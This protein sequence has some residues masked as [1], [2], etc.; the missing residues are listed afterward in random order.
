MR[1]DEAL[2]VAA[3]ASE[4]ADADRLAEAE[5]RYRE[6]IARA[7]PRHY[8]TPDI[9]LEYAA[10]LTRLDRWNDA[11]LQ[12]ERALQLELQ[13]DP[14]ESQAMTLTLRYLLGEHYLRLGDAESARRV[15][16]PSLTSPKPLAW[17]VEAEALYLSGSPDQARQAGERALSLADGEQRERIRERLAELWDVVAE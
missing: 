9:H 11:G 7:D 2:A 6:A 10:V 13:N 16:A 1:Q 14:D 17:I 15:I 5:L 3:E 8:R 4:L 12:Y